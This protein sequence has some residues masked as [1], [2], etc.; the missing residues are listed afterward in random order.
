MCTSP[1]TRAACCGAGWPLLQKSPIKETIFCKRHPPSPAT[2]AACCGARWPGTMN[3][4]QKSALYLHD[5]ANRVASWLLGTCCRCTDMRRFTMYIILRCIPPEKLL[6]D[7]FSTPVP[8]FSLICTI[9]SNKPCILDYHQETNFESSGVDTSGRVRHPPYS[10]K[11]F[12]R[13]T[14]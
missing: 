5:S 8:L 14:F 2:R 11:L 13:L 6:G 4:S 10:K 1:A 3:H 9:I 7:G 12:M